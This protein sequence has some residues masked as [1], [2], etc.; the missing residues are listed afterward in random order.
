MTPRAFSFALRAA[1]KV[2]FAASVAGCSSV[3]IQEAES[4]TEADETEDPTTSSTSTSSSTSSSAATGSSV[5]TGGSTS[6]GTVPHPPVACDE[7]S[8]GWPVY[9]DATFACCVSSTSEQIE[10][11]T[12]PG[13]GE[14]DT[15]VLGCCT[16]IIADNYEAIWSQAP[17]VHDAPL[18]VVAAC[19]MVLHGNT[20][21]T[22]WGPPAPPAID[23]DGPASG[24][25]VVYDLRLAARPLAPSV[26]RP[27]NE[28]QRQAAIE[29]W[30]GRMVNET[31]SAA[32][33]EAL[34]VELE[35]AGFSPEWTRACA[36][37]AEEERRHG[38]LC[39]AVVEALGG[40]AVGVRAGVERL[41]VH[42]D[43]SQL[44]AS[45]RNVLSVGC[46][47]ETV[48]VALIGAERFEMEEGELRDLLTRIWADE[49]GHAR[50][51]WRFVEAHA[52]DLDEVARVRLARYLRVAFRELERHELAH[53]PESARRGERGEALGLCDGGAART[54]FYATVN[55]VIIPRL[56]ALG[57]QATLAW[58][59]RHDRR[60]PAELQRCA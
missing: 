12:M 6:T 48:A 10:N 44:E 8:A 39:G 34:A 29:T 49:I 1:T 58:R 46:L 20:G 14:A 59:T 24:E 42:D 16:Q 9:D 32:V 23:C 55:E 60:A 57:L 19:C 54:L 13:W 37:F 43:V 27:E 22:P 17:L 5:T 52:S 26:A 45:I 40:E 2:A 21:C 3:I 50:F 30:R 35:R 4:E 11:G 31:A 38:V 15:D 28:A 47:S 56:D 53:L 18:E 36:A 25:R 7:P 41:P 33:F 51:G